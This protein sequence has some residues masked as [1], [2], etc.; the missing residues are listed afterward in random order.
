MPRKGLS[1]PKLEALWGTRTILENTTNLGE[2]TDT[3][4]A[5]PPSQTKVPVGLPGGA[6]ADSVELSVGGPLSTLQSGGG[7]WKPQI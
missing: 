6:G 3:E 7:G 1:A 5:S 4:D 2:R